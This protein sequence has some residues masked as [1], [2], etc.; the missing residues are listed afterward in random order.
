M[1]IEKNIAYNLF[2][3]M[4]ADEYLIKI[5]TDLGEKNIYDS[6]SQCNRC[7]YCFES[8]PSY[9]VKRQENYS[10]R[11]RNQLIKMIAEERLSPERQPDT[12]YDSLFTCLACGACM[13]AC[14][15][16]VAT[17][18]NVVETRRYFAKKNHHA[19]Y[20][21]FLN[22]LTSRPHK[23]ALIFNLYGLFGL[24]NPYLKKIKPKFSS[25]ENMAKKH[26]VL[27]ETKEPKCLYFVSCVANYIY[28]EIADATA[29]LADKYIGSVAMFANRCCGALQFVYNG[30]KNAK[31]IAK[32]NISIYEKIAGEKDITVIT[33]C[34]SCSYHLK[35]YPEMFKNDTLWYEKALRFSRN[36]K[37]IIEVV[38]PDKIKNNFE[39]LAQSVTYHH[40]ACSF[41]KQEI[42]P[43]EAVKL[44]AGKNFRQMPCDDIA[45]GGE[46][47]FNFVKP[48]IAE[49][50]IKRKIA[51][52]AS[53]QSD[54]VSTSDG[55]SLMFIDYGLKRYYPLT[56]P[57]H[58]STLLWH[59][60]NATPLK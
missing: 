55:F 29:R 19:G 44:I 27:A 47:G 26:P 10:A 17:H 40:S 52:I 4:S 21:K 51:N 46:L 18:K 54:L 5:N 49:K 14:Y 35:N 1:S 57:L 38:T 7:G 9:I 28:P 33:D 22:I 58:I 25:F 56:K 53:T 39:P 8:C 12:I 50:L 20:L 24:K 34:S 60:I 41:H 45:C 2:G 43:V 59:Q 16:K 37:D 31:D 23:L 11:G 15:G 6:A 32:K 13:S 48:E 3:K 30:L 36:I 42:S